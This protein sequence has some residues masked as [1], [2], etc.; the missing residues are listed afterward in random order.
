MSQ[1]LESLLDAARLAACAENDQALG[2]TE[3][4]R[5]EADLLRD[6]RKGPRLAA[7]NDAHAADLQ[8]QYQGFIGGL[9]Q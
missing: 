7:I 9:P 5:V 8:L 2:I 1:H 6:V 3:A 4:D